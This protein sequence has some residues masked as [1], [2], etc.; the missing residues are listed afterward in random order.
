MDSSSRNILLKN[1]DDVEA[2]FDI[3]EHSVLSTNFMD[4]NKRKRK[5]ETVK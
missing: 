4:G 5:T 2:D 3:N 1:E